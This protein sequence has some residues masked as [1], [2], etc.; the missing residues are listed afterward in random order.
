MTE[1]AIR[2]QTSSE[3]Y[4][5]SKGRS[6]KSLIA[7]CAYA[8]AHRDRLPHAFREVREPGSRV[9]LG[10]SCLHFDSIAGFSSG[11]L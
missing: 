11:L 1:T 7:S 2:T 8:L 9:E 10:T 5:E 3:R 6:A 4:K